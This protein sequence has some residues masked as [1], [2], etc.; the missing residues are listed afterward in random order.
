MFQQNKLI[1]LF[2]GQWF[3]IKFRDGLKNLIEN[4]RAGFSLFHK[5]NPLN[6]E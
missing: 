2:P 3:D 4:R 1:F 5:R 6:V